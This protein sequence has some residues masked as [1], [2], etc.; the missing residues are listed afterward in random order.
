M[1]KVVRMLG[2]CALV[3]LA[4][5]SCKKNETNNAFSFKASMSQ[6]QSN[7]RTWVAEEDKL[8]WSTGDNILV[9]D[10]N[11][12]NKDFTA[13]TITEQDAVFEVNDSEK[14]DF[15]VDIATPNKYTAFYPKAK[16]DGA[17][18]VSLVIPYTQDYNYVVG[19][20]GSFAT[21][22]YPM[23]GKN[24]QA[25]HFQFNSHAGILE[26][27]FGCRLGRTV[28]VKSIII[29][30]LDNADEL[31]GKMTYRY[32]YPFTTPFN[33]VADDAYVTDSITYVVTLDCTKGSDGGYI[34]PQPS[35]EQSAIQYNRFDIAL[36]RGALTNGF[37]VTVLGDKNDPQEPEVMR[38]NVI[39]LNQD[40]T[41]NGYEIE[42]QTI[43]S[44]R[45][46]I[47]PAYGDGE[48]D[49]YVE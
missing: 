36:L 41:G 49:G 34:L 24:D 26:F 10:Q 4:F 30:S 20:A 23:F 42:A 21:E 2:L 48:G 29:T 45:R 25:K 43:T 12:E 15:L 18:S 11:K 47:L 5:T 38:E 31:A 19:Q 3:A 27:N 16:F 37:N 28:K 22:T 7:D 40:I 14:V 32:D 44:F 13:T 1:K 6:P 9:F 8:N 46:R 39:L 33:P 17:E 35:D